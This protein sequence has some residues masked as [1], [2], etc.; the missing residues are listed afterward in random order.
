MSVTLMCVLNAALESRKERGTRQQASE[1]PCTLQSG[2][3]NAMLL[4]ERD[5]DYGWEVR[6]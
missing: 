6:R 4:V 3:R 1:L 5:P 2:E